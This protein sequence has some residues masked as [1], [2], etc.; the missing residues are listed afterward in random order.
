MA[1]NFAQ[2]GNDLYTGRRSYD[3]VGRRT[4]WFVISGVLVV[5][6]A[7]LL[8]KPGLQPGIEFRG[9]SEFTVSN[10]SSTDQ[11]PAVDAVADRFGS[12]AV[13]RGALLRHGTGLEVPML[14]DPGP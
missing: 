10:A 3:I 7:I 6:S 11:Q 4:R 9:G 13:V 8:F 5:L 1:V 14:P 12:G 2:W